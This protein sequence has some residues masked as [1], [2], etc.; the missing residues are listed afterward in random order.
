[1]WRRSS[2]TVK[3]LR[4]FLLRDDKTARPL[5]V[6]MRLRKP[7]LFLRFVF[8]GWYVRFMFSQYFYPPQRG[9][10]YTITLLLDKGNQKIS[11]KLLL[12][13][14]TTGGKNSW[15]KRRKS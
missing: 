8:E 5:A 6:A 15:Q 3:L 14:Q 1:L 10:K 13:S 7:C 4:P 2:E 11:L 12:S 9:G